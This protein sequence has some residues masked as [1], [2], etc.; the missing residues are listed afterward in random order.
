MEEEMKY[1]LLLLCSLLINVGLS[2]LL[3]VGKDKKSTKEIFAD[4]KFRCF[5]DSSVVKISSDDNNLFLLIDRNN[6]KLIRFQYSLPDLSQSASI[7]TEDENLQRVSYH[8]KDYTLTFIKWKENSGDRDFS[9]G[10][11]KHKKDNPYGLEYYSQFI[12]KKDGNYEIVQ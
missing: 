8:G 12:F 1:K 10:V 2:V 7:E 5:T 3:F 11:Y 4:E 9:L 6:D